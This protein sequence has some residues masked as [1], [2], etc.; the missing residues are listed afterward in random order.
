MARSGPI[1]RCND[2]ELDALHSRAAT[3]PSQLLAFIP[4]SENSAWTLL[5]WQ[6]TRLPGLARGEGPLTT[7]EPTPDVWQPP[8]ARCSS[9]PSLHSSISAVSLSLSARRKYIGAPYLG[10]GPD[11]RA[12]LGR[13]GRPPGQDP[14]C[15]APTRDPSHS[16]TLNFSAWDYPAVYDQRPRTW[17][18]TQLEH[19]PTGPPCL[20][21]T[22][23]RSTATLLAVS[24]TPVSRTSSAPNTLLSET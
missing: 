5:P 11:S 3:T 6:R 2:Q 7:L 21:P 23:N 22:T 16:H 13:R 19:Q 12:R 9:R 17:R 18:R 8:G 15:T 10:S 4:A 20:T 14:S 24:T 1:Q